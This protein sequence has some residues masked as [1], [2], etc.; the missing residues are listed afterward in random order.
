MSFNFYQRLELIGKHIPYGHVVTY[1]QLALLCG[2][3]KNSRQVGY[4]LRSDKV[5]KDF[6]AYR[7]INGQGYLSGAGAFATPGLQKSMLQKEGV[8]VSP[9]NRV[10]MKQFQWKH[11]MEDAVWFRELFRQLG[12]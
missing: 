8:E 3:P 1:G 10:E 4:A 11:T 6:P 2:K 5:G 9:D 7:V 12:V